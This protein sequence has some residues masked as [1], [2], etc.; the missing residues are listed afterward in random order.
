MKIEYRDDAEITVE[1]AIDL[2]KKSTLGKRRPIDRPE[3]FA[4]ML[5]NA[6]LTIS[7]KI[8]GDT[9]RISPFS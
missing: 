3:I 6:N 5:K 8:M 4:G 2:Y 1:V 7:G 9:I